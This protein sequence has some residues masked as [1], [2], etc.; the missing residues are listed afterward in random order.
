ML[1]YLKAA[2]TNHWNLLGL[3]AGTGVAVI[4]GSYDVVLP[5]VLA[6]EAAYLTLVGTNAKFQNYVDVGE[7]REQRA[8]RSQQNQAALRQMIRSLPRQM[9]D[10]YRQLQDQCQELQNIAAD[11][12]PPAGG[13]VKESLESMQ[14]ES[15]DRLLWIYLRL[16]FTYHSLQKFLERTSIERIKSDIQRIN[17]RLSLLNAD[18]QSPHTQK[19]R[20]TLEDN[21]VTSQDRVRNYERARANHEFVELEIDRLENKIKSLAEIA[22]NRQEPDYVSSQVD[23]VANSMLETEKT[24]NDLQVFTGLGNLDE[25]VPIM[26]DTIP[27]RGR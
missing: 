1:K 4:S 14:S 16:L 18:D 13:P 17:K 21:L 8:L 9:L 12:K 27:Q 24:M 3:M 7:H 6:A 26:L 19:M 11:L 25:E 22:V 20:R 15:L 2:F 23:Q 5:L 10:R